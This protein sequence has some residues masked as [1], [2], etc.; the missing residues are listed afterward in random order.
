M[1]GVGADRQNEAKEEMCFPGVWAVDEV[2][3][4]LIEAV[5]K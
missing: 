5:T 2:L 3:K 4:R 1:A